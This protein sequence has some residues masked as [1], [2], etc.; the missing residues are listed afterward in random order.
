MTDIEYS[1]S[2]DDD[3]ILKS[4]RRI[5]GKLD[6]LAD[7]GNKS[8][9]RIG[10]SSELSATKI[11]VVSGVVSTLTTQ[12]INL[13]VQATKSFKALIDESVDLARTQELA[14]RQI[15]ATL[16]STNFQAGLTLKDLKDLA[17]G[18]Q[19]ITNVGDEAT[20]SA[21]NLLLTFKGIGGEIFPDVTK[22]VVDMTAG[23]N[24]G[25]VTTEGLKSSALQLGKALDD[26][27]A[28]VTALRRSGVSFTESQLKQIKVLTESGKAL[29]AQRLI[30]REVESQFGGSA[31]A[32]R[33]ARIQLSNF[34]GD[35]QEIGGMPVLDALRDS[36]ERL[37]QI[38]QDNQP[39]IEAI[40]ES[41]GD[42]V[43]D[44]VDFVTTIG[45]DFIENLDP[46][47]I[48]ETVDHFKDLFDTA[49][50][51]ADVLS[52]MAFD[53]EFLDSVNKLIEKLNKA[54][55]S[56]AKLSAIA[57]IKSAEQN[58]RAQEAAR[59]TGF[60]V[61]DP[62]TGQKQIAPFLVT[63]FLS[64]EDV[65]KI[66]AAGEA[67]G[68]AVVEDILPAFEAY[69]E[70]LEEN[71]KKNEERN[72]AVEQGAQVDRAAAA[73][74]AAAA[75]T[76]AQEEVVEKRAKLEEDLQERLLKI[77][78]DGERRR[79][80]DEIKAAQRRE[81]L[82]RQNADKLADIEQR[83]TERLDDAARDLDRGEADLARKQAQERVQIDR[84]AAKRREDIE[85]DFRREL[86]RI[87]ENFL[88]NAQE[89][90][91]TNDAR[92]FLELQRQ[93]TQEIDAA[94]D[95]RDESLSD[96]DTT[97]QRE[98]DRAKEQAAQE[99]EAVREKNRRALE[100]LQLR[101]DRELEAQAL[102][103][104]RALE[105]QAIAEQRQAEQRAREEARKLEDFQRTEEQKRAALEASLADQLALI[106]DFNSRQIDAAQSTADRIAEIY[107][108]VAEQA[109]A[110]SSRPQGIYA[111][112]PFADLFRQAGGTVAGGQPYVVGERG[113]ELFVPNQAGNI[114]PNRVM[115]SPPA[116]G[117]GSQFSQTNVTNNPTFNVAEDMLD[118]PVMQN[119]LRNFV[120]GILAEAS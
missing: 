83:N 3:Q 28:G 9:G 87:R 67:A 43:A 14:E 96:S 69:D 26:P 57:E 93:N 42:L 51:L 20:L 45:V 119:R 32:S 27:V 52:K 114:V 117:G 107:R 24:A 85:R 120:L 106:E 7:Q 46:E 60:G 81:D 77:Q 98:V 2:I 17:G 100:D 75:A 31:E 10:K 72:E 79:L 59:I 63:P 74:A 78:M 39:E 53:G 66:D 113:P 108:G 80:D 11:G 91:R 55:E 94:R 62:L 44:L 35:L 4:L 76:D 70:A 104:E 61:K 18:L 92:R 36:A 38:L 112:N 105:A 116:P 82:A 23:L 101:L 109:E 6:D 41:V 86:E 97:R 8:F 56:G 58:A 115:F 111:G 84:D 12:I 49:K 34:I 33:D 95:K 110:G 65:A 40:A 5:D 73:A 15:L 50:L 1:A 89:A 71:K 68:R 103:N 102:A 64:E 19:N 47:K 21:I 25:V 90:E 29:E 16:K 22:A 118:N 54:V 88:L 37:L 99:L 30:L 48:Q 13:G